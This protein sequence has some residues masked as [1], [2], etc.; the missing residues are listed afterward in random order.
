MSVIPTR[1]NAVLT[2]DD[3]ATLFY[4]EQIIDVFINPATDEWEYT[5]EWRIY[6]KQVEAVSCKEVRFDWDH[7]RALQVDFYEYKEHSISR[8]ST[9]DVVVPETWTA[10][11]FLRLLARSVFEDTDRI[12]SINI[13][14]GTADINNILREYIAIMD[15]VDLAQTNDY[16]RVVEGGD[17]FLQP[18]EDN[19]RDGW[20]CQEFTRARV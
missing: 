3:T 7:M 2:I 18:G 1:R 12:I 4:N 11:T 13:S 20:V 17:L 5:N 6:R 14:Q 19:G 15:P 8:C 16:D 10:N 9:V